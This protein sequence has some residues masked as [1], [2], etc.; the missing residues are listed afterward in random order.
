MS[1]T[2]IVTVTFTPYPNSGSSG[3]ASGGSQITNGSITNPGQQG[4]VAQAVQG[5]NGGVPLPVAE[6]GTI[7]KDRSANAPVGPGNATSFTF[8]GVVVHLLQTI[9]ANPSRLS[10][11]VNNT[12]GAAIVVVTDDGFNTGGT[13][14]MFPLAPGAGANQQG[15]DLTLTDELGRVR[16]FG[17]TGTYC[18]VREN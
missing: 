2:T 12:T 17:A 7:G 5:I 4:Q 9:V 11:E 8:N 3:G 6:A 10:L 13:V 18:Y 14:S 15:A 1:G 16:I